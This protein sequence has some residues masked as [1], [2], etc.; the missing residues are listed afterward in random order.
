MKLHLRELDTLCWGTESHPIR[1]ST[2]EQGDLI[3]LEVLRWWEL[4]RRWRK[5]GGNNLVAR[6]V[7]EVK[8]A[9]LPLDTEG[10]CMMTK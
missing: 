8:I 2:F 1:L 5:I 7:Q 3:G 10:N 4:L 6:Q 9:L